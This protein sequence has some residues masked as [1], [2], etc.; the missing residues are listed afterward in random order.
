[1]RQ[2]LG[3][4]LLAVGAIAVYAAVT[5]NYKAALAAIGINLSTGSSG[6]SLQLPPLPNGPGNPGPGGIG[7]GIIPT[8]PTAPG[9]KPGIVWS[10]S[11]IAAPAPSIGNF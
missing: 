7:G 9:P 10:S 2:L 3:L 6:G 1:M 8:I 11:T 5:G 4:G